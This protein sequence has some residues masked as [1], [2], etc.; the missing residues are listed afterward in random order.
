M[1]LLH[2][3]HFFLFVLATP[4]CQGLQR[5]FKPIFYF[6][7]Y[8]FFTDILVLEILLS[9]NY[10]NG[11]Q[12]FPSR[13]VLCDCII[14]CI[15]R[16]LHFNQ[17]SMSLYRGASWHEHTSLHSPC[18]SNIFNPFSAA[19]QSPLMSYIYQLLVKVR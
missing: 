10:I 8:L 6:C 15:N 2:S 16:N 9:D 14:E 17:E 11:R 4:F 7:I 18:C 13:L 19:V 5:Q 3:A 12:R 1:R